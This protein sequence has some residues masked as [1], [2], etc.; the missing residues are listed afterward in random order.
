MIKDKHMIV[1]RECIEKDI[2]NPEALEITYKNDKKAFSKIIEQMHDE[3]IN[4]FA[5]EFWYARKP[6]NIFV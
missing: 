5:V 6:V 3:A 4:S 2:N 1:T